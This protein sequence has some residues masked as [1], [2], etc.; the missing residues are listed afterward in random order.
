[1]VYPIVE[2]EQG[3]MENKVP[4]PQPARARAVERAILGVV[5]DAHT[6]KVLSTLNPRNVQR[7]H[8][9]ITWRTH[10]GDASAKEPSDMKEHSVEQVVKF[11]DVVAHKLSIVPMTIRAIIQAM[12][13]QLMKTMYSTVSESTE[14]SGNVVD[15]R[16][17]GSLE[18]AFLEMLRKIEFGVDEA[19]QVSLP[20]IHLAPGN[21]LLD[22]LKKAGPEFEAQVDAIINEKRAKALE[23]ERERLSK[24]K[25][26]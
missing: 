7:M 21:P 1:M 24:F 10:S 13:D 2:F 6:Q 22:Q 9:G 18:Q 17:A 20:E 12:S 8:H 25:T 16:E 14:R 11:E 3:A 15:A 19:G 4:F 23:R 5:R 26:Q